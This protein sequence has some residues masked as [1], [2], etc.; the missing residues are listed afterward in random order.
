[1]ARATADPAVDA[2]RRPVVLPSTNPYI[3][4]QVSDQGWGHGANAAE[5]CM[6][7]P[8]GKCSENSDGYLRRRDGGQ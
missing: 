4:V 5:A 2:V 1:M 3:P 7:L 6:L 8:G